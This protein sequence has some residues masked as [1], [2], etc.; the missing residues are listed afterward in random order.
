MP[1]RCGK[2]GLI[3]DALAGLDGPM[4]A[5]LWEYIIKGG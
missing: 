5:A 4:K 3:G 1:R 2:S